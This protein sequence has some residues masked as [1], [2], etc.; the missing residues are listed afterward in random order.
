MKT[1]IIVF[2]LLII[3]LSSEP[4][5]ELE[6]RPYFNRSISNFQYSTQV[7]YSLIQD[8]MEQRNI[9]G[10]KFKTVTHRMKGIFS[11]RFKYFQIIRKDIVIEV[12]AAPVGTGF[13]ITSRKGIIKGSDTWKKQRERIISKAGTTN[14]RKANPDLFFQ[15]DVELLF[16]SSV[17]QSVSEAIDSAISAKGIRDI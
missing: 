5:I 1:A 8:A 13:F 7:F 6:E 4:E 14:Y 11:P 17:Q 2:I 9:P 15:L 3:I 10:V 16:L 12:C